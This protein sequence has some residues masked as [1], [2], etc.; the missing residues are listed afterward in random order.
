MNFINQHDKQI[1]A[2]GVRCL[3]LDTPVKQS[4]LSSLVERKN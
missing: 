2:I 3:T 1:H 4:S